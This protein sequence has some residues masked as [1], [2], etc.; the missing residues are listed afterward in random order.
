MQDKNLKFCMDQL[1]SLQNRDGLEPGQRSE[2]E[3]AMEA[4]RRLWRKPNP[5]RK[6][7][8]VAV[9]LVAEAILTSFGK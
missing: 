4:L 9:R 1:R 8:Y 5:S 3:R 6:E 2:L 7:I